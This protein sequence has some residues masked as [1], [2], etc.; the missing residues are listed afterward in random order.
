LTEE[1][2][3]GTEKEQS[4]GNGHKHEAGNGSSAG[5]V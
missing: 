3:I 2:D 1:G 4:N 5:H